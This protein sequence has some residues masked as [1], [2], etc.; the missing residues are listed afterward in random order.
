MQTKVAAIVRPTDEGQLLDRAKQHD[1]EAISELYNRHVD[2]IYQYVRY[3]T[4]DVA[5]AEDI[6]AD[7]FLRALESLDSYDDRGVP[8]SAWLYR[9]AQ[10]RVI[11][12]WRRN[13]RRAVV[14]LGDPDVS[15]LPA[16]EEPGRDVW[17]LRQLTAAL[18]L[19]TE[20][21]QHVITLKFVQNLGNAEIAQTLNKT[22]GAVK[23]LQRRGLE[24]LARILKA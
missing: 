2:R 8:F 12:H 20:D 15:D 3:R 1:P 23:A 21:Q 7:V 5:L 18:Q 16:E 22:E 13:Q 19:L 10:A 9:I 6:T 24:A 4:D 11:D 14:P 17:Q